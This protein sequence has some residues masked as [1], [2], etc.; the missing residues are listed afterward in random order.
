LPLSINNQWNGLMFSERH[1]MRVTHNENHSRMRSPRFWHYATNAGFSQDVQRADSY[2]RICL[3]RE[4]SWENDT[5][6]QC[7]KETTLT[8]LLYLSVKL[9]SSRLF[10]Q[11]G[12]LENKTRV[13]PA[14]GE[15]GP[16]FWK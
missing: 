6:L 9:H 4:P 1:C 3:P 10:S 5:P 11:S 14:F 2:C 16:L 8:F 15:R 7:Y 13:G 12:K